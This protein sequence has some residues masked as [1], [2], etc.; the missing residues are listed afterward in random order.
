MTKAA[1]KHNVLQWV[2]NNA[3]CSQKEIADARVPGQVLYW[4]IYAA[5][6]LAVTERQI[7]EA[8]A[9]GFGGFA[10]TVDAIRVGKRERAI[11]IQIEEEDVSLFLLFTYS[12]TLTGFPGLRC[13]KRG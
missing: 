11:R 3:G 9:N 1:A 5:A 4:Q 10:L 2:C 6:N 13:R 12:L 7:K 8:V